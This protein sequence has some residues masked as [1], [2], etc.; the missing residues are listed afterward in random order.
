M[1][2]RRTFFTSGDRDMGRRS[3]TSISATACNVHG[4]NSTILLLMMIII[5]RIIYI[6]WLL[7]LLHI[8]TT[9][10]LVIEMM[11]TIVTVIMGLPTAFSGTSRLHQEW[12]PPRTGWDRTHAKPGG[13]KGRSTKFGDVPNEK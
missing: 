11:R 12:A 9:I 2:C 7:L 10:D 13:A 3:G 5:T 4:K 1:T 6:K 8:T